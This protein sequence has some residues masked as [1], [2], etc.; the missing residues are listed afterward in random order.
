METLH[1][2]FPLLDQ[3]IALALGALVVGALIGSLAEK[4]CFIS[5]LTQ[6]IHRQVQQVGLNLNRADRPLQTRASRGFI[7]LGLLSFAA[8][9]VGTF[10]EAALHWHP[11]LEALYLLALIA[12]LSPQRYL[13]PAF[14]AKR[15]A[16]AGNWVA[17]DAPLMALA[18]G[19]A[20]S[21]D[22][23]GKLRLTIEL[24]HHHFVHHTLGSTLAFV[25]AG[26]P[27]LLVYRMVQLCAQH[28][29][30]FLPAW[31]GF[32]W[33]SA[34][35]ASLLGLL[36]QLFAM[37]LLCAALFWLPGARPFRA[38]AVLWKRGEGS[39]S[40]RYLVQALGI[41]VGGPRMLYGQQ[42]PAPWIGGAHTAQLDGKPL[43]QWVFAALFALM[44][45]LL[46]LASA[47]LAFGPPN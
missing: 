23:H 28:Y 27:G 12:L 7:V 24:L 20:H 45:W 22:G 4:L 31:R 46:A 37:A 40:L 26:M 3:R 41:T 44:V 1:Q 42:I 30:E 39:V 32:A 17:L 15:A 5:L 36:P 9:L 10:L 34:R 33:A 13:I 6:K 29:C 14:R 47:V 38:L 35:L 8:L 16:K 25:L 18:G 11:W 19:T 2:L 43:A 21:A